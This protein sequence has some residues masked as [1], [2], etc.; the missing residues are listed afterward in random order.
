MQVPP[1][2]EM[3]TLRSKRMIHAPAGKE[4]RLGLVGADAALQAALADGQ[5][6]GAGGHA[7]V[8]VEAQE[9][10]RQVAQ[11]A[12]EGVRPDAVLVAWPARAAARD[13]FEALVRV[14]RPMAV[15]LVALCAEGP[16]QQVEA[17][18]AGADEAMML[19]LHVPLLRA[20][21]AARRRLLGLRGQAAS[22]AHR[23]DGQILRIGPLGLNE[24]QRLITVDGEAVELTPK[25]WELLGFLMRN[26]GACCT[27]GE[28][29]DNVWGID[30]ET[31][32]NMVDVYIHF[33]RQKLKA[34]GLRGMIRTV[35][36]RGYR[37][38]GPEIDPA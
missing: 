35:R 4:L 26:A 1:A 23:P 33:L 32:T 21:L 30:F 27:R 5:S 3:L 37:L 13:A 36:G 11:Q 15:A 19:P 20:R 28:I 9:A 25:E 18:R 6:G 7:L 31:G 29:L 8:P 24:R 22:A 17:L 34:H 10:A 38:V 16:G 2:D 14:P 12:P